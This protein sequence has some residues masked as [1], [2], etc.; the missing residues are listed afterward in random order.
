MIPVDVLLKWK[1][2]LYGLD[3]DQKKY[4]DCLGLA[5][6]IDNETEEELNARTLSAHMQ[7]TI[8]FHSCFVQIKRDLGRTIALPTGLEQCF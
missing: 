2:V 5:D 6:K 8:I 4:S 3:S 1:L 7:E